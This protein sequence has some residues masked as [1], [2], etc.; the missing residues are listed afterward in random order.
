MCY[1]PEIHDSPCV[2]EYMV[3]LEGTN[4]ALCGRRLLP[5]CT[6]AVPA[7]QWYFYSNVYMVEPISKSSNINQV[8]K[9][10]TY[11]CST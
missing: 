5:M 10:T 7:T 1:D 3:P 6:V 11:D 4:K 8:A 2:M 9:Q